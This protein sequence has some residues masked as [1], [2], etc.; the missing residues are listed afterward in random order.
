MR[1]LVLPLSTQIKLRKPKD[2]RNSAWVALDGATRFELKDGEDMVVEGSESNLSMVV[3]PSD[4][5]M[6]L[7]GRRL[8]HMLNWNN[9][10]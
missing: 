7:W 9:R 5:L 6:S 1:P 8:V 10:K 4:N 2:G 3:T